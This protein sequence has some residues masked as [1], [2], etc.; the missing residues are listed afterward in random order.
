MYEKYEK[1]RDE[2]GVSN[3]R[4]CEETG[5]SNASMSDWKLGKCTLKVD[6]IIKICHYFDVPLDYF[7]GD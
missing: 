3:Y 6:K 2:K 7:Y 5:I 1:L 4:V